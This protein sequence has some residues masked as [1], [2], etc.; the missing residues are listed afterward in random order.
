M[1]TKKIIIEFSYFNKLRLVRKV[2]NSN[3]TKKDDFHKLEYML[4]N[5][6]KELEKRFEEA[7]LI[8]NVKIMDYI[9]VKYKWWEFWK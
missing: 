6:K 7:F 8:Y 9:I 4:K 2:G 3:Q 5:D 1:K